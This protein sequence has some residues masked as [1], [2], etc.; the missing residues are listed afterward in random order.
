M[1]HRATL[2]KIAAKTMKL[3]I[4]ILTKGEEAYTVKQELT[5]MRGALTKAGNRLDKPISEDNKF[6]KW[7]TK[8]PF[9]KNA[10]GG[11]RGITKL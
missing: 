10:F 5:G 9:A 2:T 1:S 8:H 4:Q 6:G 7:L 11:L 3:K